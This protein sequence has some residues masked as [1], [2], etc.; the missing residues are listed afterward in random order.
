L[1]A[2]NISEQLDDLMLQALRNNV[3][4]EDLFQMLMM[5]AE[6]VSSALPLINAVIDARSTGGGNHL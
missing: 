5:K 6:R 1:S 4:P 3:P 2:K